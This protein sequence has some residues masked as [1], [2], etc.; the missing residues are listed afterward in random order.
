[1]RFTE[2]VIIAMIGVALLITAAFMPSGDDTH[3]NVITSLV[4]GG[5][6]FIAA[7]ITMWTHQLRNSN[8]TR[9]RKTDPPAEPYANY[10]ARPVAPGKESP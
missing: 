1:V 9:E 8:T 5:T 10:D 3:R 6:S 2:I 7:A 4:S